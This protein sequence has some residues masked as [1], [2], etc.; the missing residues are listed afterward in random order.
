VT[1]G[2]SNKIIRPSLRSGYCYQQKQLI[3]ACVALVSIATLNM[4]VLMPL[5]AVSAGKRAFG[6]IGSTV[7]CLSCCS[8]LNILGNP[9]AVSGVAGSWDGE[10]MGSIVDT[11]WDLASVA[12][13]GTLELGL[14][15]STV[16]QDTSCCLCWA[17]VLGEPVTLHV[18]ACAFNLEHVRAA[19]LASITRRRGRHLRYG[20]LLRYRRL[21]TRL[22]RWSLRR[23][24]R[25]FDRGLAGGLV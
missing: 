15:I 1:G 17:T 6:S 11:W 14:G 5:Q 4:S 24:G 16:F 19:I 9:C 20:R 25:G 2:R 12:A 18:Y 3:S 10:G 8:S 23:L 21:G 7:S 13:L 22:I